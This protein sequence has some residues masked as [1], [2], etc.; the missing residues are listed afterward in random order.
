MFSSQ[1]SF[2]LGG[3]N[4]SEW[5]FSFSLF[6]SILA[7]FPSNPHVSP[8]FHIIAHKTQ[9][10]RVFISDQPFYERIKSFIG[11][12]QMIFAVHI[13]Y[14]ISKMYDKECSTCCLK[15]RL[16]SLWYT[17]A[18]SWRNIMLTELEWRENEHCSSTAL[19]FSFGSRVSSYNLMASC[20]NE[21]T[22]HH[23]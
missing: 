15:N 14:A 2:F 19:K 9:H 12:V 11:N 8:T 7:F 3:V 23:F 16:L 13:Y 17:P 20:V 6:K 1:I 22:R 21:F 4:R 18:M 5:Y 10:F